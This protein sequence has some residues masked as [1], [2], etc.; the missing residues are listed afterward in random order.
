[1]IPIRA[2]TTAQQVHDWLYRCVLRGDLLP[3]T[4]LSETEIAAQ[5][6]L[7]RQPVREA[8][9]RLAADGLAEVLPQR[10]TYIGRISMRA[11]LSARFIREAV[12]SDLARHVAATRPDLTAM[13]AEL[14]VQERCDVEGDVPGFI[15][16]DDRFHRAMALAA[17]QGAVWQDLER[18]KAQMN[19]LRHLS[20]RVFDRSQTIAQHRAVLTALQAGDADG[21]EDAIRT[22]LRQM[23]T[24]LPQMAAAHPDYFTD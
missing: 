14:T 15:E 11:V 10:G 22:H 20:M 21:A 23:L 17:D 8:F 19:R 16:S 4:R 18:L 6:N 12:E 5:V 1:M 24:E 13:A 7:S 2:A 3:G 9:I